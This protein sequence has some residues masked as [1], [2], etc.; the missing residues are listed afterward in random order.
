M[1]GKLQ[2]SAQWVIPIIIGSCLLALFVLVRPT[3]AIT[4]IPNPEPK[5]GSFGLEATKTQD[6]PTQGATITTP[7][8]GAS[9][10][11]SPVTV[12]GIC[13]TDLLV[14]VYNNN[15]MVG[16]VMCKGGS[17]SVQVSL[18]A[19]INELTAIVY[20]S[21][22]QAGPGSNT[23]TVNYTDTNFTAF[24]ALITLTSS[25]GRRSAAAGSELSWPLQL[26]G[27]TGPYAF[28]I[29][30]GDG[31]ATELKSQ[32][33]AGLVAI[34]H[35]YKKAGI[36]QA[37]IKV[38]DVNGVSAFLQVIAVANGKVD[39]TPAAPDTSNG[40]EVT[41]ILWIP[42]AVSLVLLPAAY[43][44]GRRSQIVSLRNKMLKEREKIK[45]V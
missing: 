28:S 23:I 32:S 37:N 20:D 29:D 12:N 13:P 26:S 19:G 6:P 16:A 36:Y 15:V 9:F 33:L 18:F 24:G 30:W 38:T 2:T 8:N 22:E 41:K 39:T 21:L 14:Q 5:P 35:V 44:L 25:Y 40:G 45:E 1:V 11:T 43:W 27:G 3:S 17:F 42:A 4:P 7:G 34:T 31:S 10:N